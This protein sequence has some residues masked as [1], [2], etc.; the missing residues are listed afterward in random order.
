[1]LEYEDRLL[2]KMTDQML[3]LYI[4]DGIKV[5]KVDSTKFLEVIINEKLSWVSHSVS[6]EKTSLYHISE[7]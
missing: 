6:N 7:F 4:I 2:V 3:Y 1:V 5:S